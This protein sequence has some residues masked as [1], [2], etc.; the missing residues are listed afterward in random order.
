M[1]LPRRTF[2]HLAAYAAAVPAFTRIVRAQPYPTRPVRVVVP[3]AAGGPL[4]ILARLMG[5]HEA[6]FNRRDF[7]EIIARQ[8]ASGFSAIQN[9]SDLPQGLKPRL[10]ALW[11][12]RDAGT[13]MPL[14]SRRSRSRC[15]RSLV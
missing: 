2:L 15:Q 7:K 4:D 9:N 10:A 11:T 12:A 13:V 5:T 8:M 1:K 6:G 14:W 3:F